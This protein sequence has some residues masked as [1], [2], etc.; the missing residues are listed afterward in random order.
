MGGRQPALITA[1]T[2]EILE[3]IGHGL[4]SKTLAFPDLNSPIL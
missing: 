2:E 1:T 4:R 3:W